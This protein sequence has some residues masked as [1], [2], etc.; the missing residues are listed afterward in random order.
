MFDSLDEY[1]LTKFKTLLEAWLGMTELMELNNLLLLD[2][3]QLNSVLKLV[4][5]G[6]IKSKVLFKS[7]NQGWGVFLSKGC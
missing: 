2:W 3:I 4:S 7:K 5:L 1:N 6:L